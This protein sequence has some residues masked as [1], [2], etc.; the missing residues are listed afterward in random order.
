VSSALSRPGKFYF[1]TRKD[2][3]LVVGARNIVDGD[4]EVSGES[5]ARRFA[6]REL[7]V[8]RTSGISSTFVAPVREVRGEFN[9]AEARRRREVLPSRSGFR[10]GGGGAA[11]DNLGSKG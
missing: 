5:A 7:D 11:P 4:I 2:D 1:V 6:R 9:R 10:L 8:R 3:M